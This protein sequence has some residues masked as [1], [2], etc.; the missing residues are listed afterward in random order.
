MP[1]LNVSALC[2]VLLSLTTSIGALRAESVGAHLPELKQWSEK[3]PFDKI[4]GKD[5]WST[6]GLREKFIETIGRDEFKNLTR[7]ASN[8]PSGPIEVWGD[9]VFAGVCMKGNCH[10][11]RFDFI[12]D[13]KTAELYVCRATAASRAKDVVLWSSGKAK[14][15][16]STG[17]CTIA[18]ETGKRDD[19][20][21]TRFLKLIPAAVR[22]AD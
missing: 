12:V 11:E 20:Y 16:R 2:A 1:S 14:N 9:Y 17:E 18:D 13:T 21:F 10:D 6:P 15:V 19:A 8:G 4:A 5:F 3:Y 22:S 7:F